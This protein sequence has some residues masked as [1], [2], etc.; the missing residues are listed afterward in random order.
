M[1]VLEALSLAKAGKVYDLG[2]EWF[3]G[4]P[5]YPTHPPFMFSLLRMHRPGGRG[6]RS[7]AACIFSSGGHTGSHLDAFGHTGS[8][9][10]VFGHD[11]SIFDKQSWGLG[12]GIG[13]IQ[14]TKP[15]ITRGVLL[16]VPRVHGVDV[17]ADKY[18]I[19]ASDLAECVKQE[20]ISVPPGAT[21]LV[22]TGWIKHWPDQDRYGGPEY[23]PGLGDSACTW[24]A[25]QR[26]RF[27]GS[28]TTAFGP[29]AGS[30]PSGNSHLIL[31][32]EHGIQIME[33]LNFEELS[34]DRVF[35][36]AFVCLPLK[37][38]GGTASPIRPVAIA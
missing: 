5:H 19:S 1:S 23:A 16:D 26:A 12:L 24:I 8:Q 10:R 37:I 14:E 35:E 34:A 38:R 4:M 11:E 33:V 21:I 28:D 20:G 30:V 18:E 36:F 25:E 29:V 17:L 27:A 13:G 22:R 32:N 2:Q 31:Q 3:V 7:G 15:I 9:G 6:G